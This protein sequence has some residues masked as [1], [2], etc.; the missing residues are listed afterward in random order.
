MQPSDTHF[1]EEMLP[2][3]I[4][5]FELAR[6]GMATVRCPY[7]T[8]HPESALSEIKPVAHRSPDAVEREPPYKLR[9]NAPLQDQI[10]QEPP[11]LIISESSAN[12]SLKPETATEPPR[13]I[14]LATTFP[15]FE[16]AR[17]AHASLARVEPQHY[18]AQSDE[19]VLA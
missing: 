9:V 15:N 19:V 10:F 13:N 1:A 3:E 17:G 7:G 18:F 6:G 4:A 12:S 2:V 8:A 16:F 14:I 5:G 11:N